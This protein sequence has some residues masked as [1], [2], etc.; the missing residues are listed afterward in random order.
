M[1]LWKVIR[2]G[3]REAQ[4]YMGTLRLDESTMSLAETVLAEMTNKQVRVG[5]TSS[6]LGAVYGPR[7]ARGGTSGNAW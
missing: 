2:G 7:H 5:I 6:N 3:A 1:A 4:G